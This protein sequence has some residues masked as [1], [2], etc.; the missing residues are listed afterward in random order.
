MLGAKHITLVSSDLTLLVAVVCR[1][2]TTPTFS[3]VSCIQVVGEVY[4]GQC[5]V[6]IV[7]I[8]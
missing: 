4:V 3:E 1:E 6:A 5:V 8:W 7:I 2:L